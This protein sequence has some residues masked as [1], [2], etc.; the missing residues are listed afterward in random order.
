[1]TA[2]GGNLSARVPGM[3][4]AWITPS[5]VFKGGLSADDMVRIDFQAK[6]IGGPP[7]LVPSVEAAVHAGI[8]RTRPDAMAIIHTH[9]PYSTVMA[10]L[11]LDL[12]AV[13]EEAINYVGVPRIPFRPSGSAELITGVSTALSGSDQVVVANHGVFA[14]GASLRA[15]ANDVLSLESACRLYLMLRQ[16]GEGLIP[17]ITDR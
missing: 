4:C 5:G 11:E 13:S 10:T 2:L 1:V 3:A 6:V 15:V 14:C 9:S 17:S 12:T 7:G 16:H 8:Y